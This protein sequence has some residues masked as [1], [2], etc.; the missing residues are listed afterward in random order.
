MLPANTLWKKDEEKKTYRLAAT[1]V[2]L[3]QVFAKIK[4]HV[5]QT[6]DSPYIVYQ[7][8]SFVFGYPLYSLP[9]AILY[10]KETLEEQGYQVWVVHPGDTLFISWMKPQKSGGGRQ[11]VAPSHEA[12]YRPFVYDN[13]SLRVLREKMDPNFR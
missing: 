13:A 10:V 11:R 12:S 6:V 7:V 1:R 3:A 5:I 8:P 9:E 2:I 4:T